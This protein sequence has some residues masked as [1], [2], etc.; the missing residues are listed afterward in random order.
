MRFS[1]ISLLALGG[2]VSML[3]QAG[4]AS[5]AARQPHPPCTVGQATLRQEPLVI[6]TARGPQHFQVEIA[7]TEP[8][9]DTGR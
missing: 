8:T 4:C 7:D 5:A 3:G 2:V 6:T 9:R 1:F